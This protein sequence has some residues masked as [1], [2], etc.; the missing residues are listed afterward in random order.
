MFS[1]NELELLSLLVE[2][3]LEFKDLNH[4]EYAEAKELSEKLDRMIE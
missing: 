4:L 2:H 1:E 3:Y